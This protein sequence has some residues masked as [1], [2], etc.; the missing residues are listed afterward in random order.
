MNTQIKEIAERIKALREIME[1]TPS[2]MAAVTEMTEAE[3]TDYEN[4]NRDFSFTFLY[5]CA[6]KFGV[7]ITELIT[8]R[9]PHL[10]FYTVTRQGEGLPINRRKGFKYQH[11]AP[12]FK[13]RKVEPFLVTAPY[14][15]EE[16]NAPIKLNSHEGQEIDYILS[17]SLKCNMD[18]H[19]EILHPGD[20]IYY[21]SGH[22]HGMIATDGEPCEFLAFVIKD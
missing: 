9:N 18:G 7:D 1:F 20:S 16:Q 21:D 3:Y 6:Q 14:I 4:G 19:V 10:S 17:G 2:E 13:G 11:I 15:P 12:N 5:S 8:G 22:N